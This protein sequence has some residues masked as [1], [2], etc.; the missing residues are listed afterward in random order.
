MRL[1]TLATIRRV[2][3]ARLALALAGTIALAAACDGPNQFA[4]PIPGTGPGGDTSPPRVEIQLPRGDSLSAKPLGDSVLVRVRVRDNVGVDSVVFIGFS[5]RGTAELG[6]D[7]IV[8]RFNS[9]KVTLPP[10]TRDTT[11]TRFLLP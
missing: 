6:T 2:R 8:A 5:E 7:T 10:N 9:K 4:T 1:Q 11:L 3:P